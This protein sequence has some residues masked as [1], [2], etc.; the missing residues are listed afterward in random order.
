MNTL[1]LHNLLLSLGLQGLFWTLF[2]LAVCFGGVY[3]A[4]LARLGWE[5]KNT[6]ENPPPKE[7][8]SAPATNTQEPIYYI[9]ENKRRHPKGDYGKPKQIHFKNG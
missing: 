5:Y 2:L 3:I 8:K 1:S 4:N 7:E 9:V 6:P